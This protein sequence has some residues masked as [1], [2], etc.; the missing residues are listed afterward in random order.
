MNEALVFIS[1]IVLSA[2]P[3]LIKRAGASIFAQT[4]FRMFVFAIGALVAAI[5]SGQSLAGLGATTTIA[6]GLL[7]LAHVGSSY[8]AF[9]ALP[10]GNAMALFYTYPVM[11]LIGTWLVYGEKI[12]TQ[13]WIWMI[14]ALIGAMLLARPGAVGWNM[15]GVVA[16]LVAAATETGIYLWFRGLSEDAL[17]WRNM[18]QMYGSSAA[19][20]SL[21]AAVAPGAI[22]SV[23]GGSA[24]IMTAF[25]LFVGFVG[26]AARFFAIPKISTAAFSSL[27]FFGIV[28]AYAF[29]W[30]FE[31]EKPTVVAATGAAAIMLANI[32]LLRPVG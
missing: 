10:A 1:E 29:G 6:A 8:K 21:G 16:A 19:M 9:E 28:A 3:I 12:A 26:Y 32:F 2:Y 31:D 5:V 15:I 7:N 20:W 23:T 25:N 4:G 13:T 22:G 30:L 11:N 24:A 17:P 14:V 18:F 27:S